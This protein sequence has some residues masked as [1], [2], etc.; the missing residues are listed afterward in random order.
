MTDGITRRA[1]LA[2]LVATPLV[3]ASPQDRN[4]Q[5][6]AAP[7][8]R[9]SSALEKLRERESSVRDTGALGDGRADDTHAIQEIADYY[10]R[11]GGEWYFPPGVFRTTA[12]LVFNCAAS[13][14]LRGRGKRGVYPGRFDP[15][16]AS[17]LAVILPVHAGRAA[18]RFT[19]SR[20]GDG[21]IELRDIALATLETGPVPTAG[22]AWDAA[23]HFLRD[24]VFINC[25][26]HGFTSAFDLF[27]TGGSN[28]QMGMFK[29]RRCTI[30]RNRWIARTLD[31]TQWNGFSFRDNEAGQNGYGPG[32]GGI[33]IAA[34]NAMIA[35][36]CLEGQRD[37]VKLTGSMRGVSVLD[38]YFEANVGTAAI[39]LQNIRGPF[40]IGANS[41]IA[42]DPAQLDHLALLS[43]CGHGRVLGPYWANGV[44]K[45]ALPI[46]GNST[47]GDNVLNPR[48]GSDPQG[49]FRLDGFDNGNTYT[50]EPQC[51]A[52]VTQR[53]TVA[54]RELAP[55][56]GRPMPVAYHNTT[57]GAAVALDIAI[58]GA[59]GDWVAMSWLFRRE[60][61]ANMPSDPY[62]SFSVNGSRAPGSRDYVAYGF[63]EYW[64]PGEWCLLTA[65][66]RLGTA[67]TRLGIGLHPFG[68]KPTLGCG[69]RYLNPI[70]Y[71]TD[72]PS[73][74]APYIDDY[75]ARSVLAPPTAKGFH[76]GDIIMNGGAAAGGQAHYVKLAGSADH[77]AYA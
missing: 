15:A 21:T 45:M 16:R 75:T 44:H 64:R 4:A 39:H 49:L 76:P 29:A 20:G 73:T 25:S 63:D 28:S 37:P 1:T 77:W 71:V 38:N 27:S 57:D 9:T 7:F 31:A 6:V 61:R 72:T 43:N 26:I 41:F 69:T 14:K 5:P 33:S 68:V 30:N 18:I 60:Q 46:L 40:D 66:I 56:N 12:P 55:W 42:C 23:D 47:A 65:A 34:H 62:V 24:F 52:L 19:G 35:G 8:I 70:V 2:T 17:E 11:V 48:S 36:N 67:M 22:I 51:S 32:D 50:R 54:G 59:V 3:H 74:I 53:V 13:Q 58:E 10:G